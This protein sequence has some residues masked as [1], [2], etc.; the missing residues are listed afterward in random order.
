MAGKIS[1]GARREVVPAVM[2][3]YRLAARA[4]KGRIIDALCATPVWPADKTIT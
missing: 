2:E 3:R 4:E 1:M